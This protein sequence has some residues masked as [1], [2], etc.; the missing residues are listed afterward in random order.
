MRKTEFTTDWYYHIFN[1]GTDK[2]LIFLQNGDLIKFIRLLNKYN[3]QNL[4]D[5]LCYVLMPNH[6]HLMLKQLKDDGISKFMHNLTISYA[7]FFNAKYQRN[8]VLFQGTFRDVEIKSDAQFVNLST[9]VHINP[10]KDRD[11]LNI[12]EKMKLLDKYLWSSYQDYIGLRNG[13]LVNKH[14]IINCVEGNNFVVDYRKL[15]R[16]HLIF[17]EEKN[18]KIEG[19]MLE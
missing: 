2:R 16:E 3:K 1:R 18:K 13:I 8:G 4:V 19:L 5:I 9:Y 15:V 14:D 12:D 11:D 17:Y 6:F 10:A 7:K